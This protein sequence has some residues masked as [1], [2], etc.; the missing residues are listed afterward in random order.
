MMFHLLIS[1]PLS[2]AG[3]SI[4][5]NDPEFS[6]DVKTDLSHDELKEIIGRYDGLIIRS[7][8]RVDRDL[9]HEAHQ[10][11]IIGRAG[12]GV[13]NID[14]DAATKA[15]I[16]VVNAPD[17]NTISAAEHTLALLMALAR[18]IPN[19][20]LSLKRGEWDRKS[21]KGVELF[22]KT[23]GII[24]MGRIGAEVAKRAK[25]F[26]MD[27]LGYDP[28]LSE[29]KAKRLGIKRAE[30]ETIFSLAD[31]ITVH[32]PLTKD[33]RH[34]INAEALKKMKRGVRLINCA[35]G[36]IIDEKAL[37]EAIIAGHVGGCA[38]DVFENEP[39]KNHPLLELEQVIATPHLGAS[40]VE[41]QEKVAADVCREVLQ[42]FHG[43][44]ARHAL[45]LPAIPDDV[46]EVLD[47]YLGLGEK[48]GE[49]AGQLLDGPPEEVTISYSGEL[50]HLETAPL[51]RSILKGILSRYL[52]DHIN[53]INVQY[54]VKETGLTY[55][56]KREQQ[57][58][59]FVGLVK[60]ALSANQKQK[61][62]SGTLLNGYGPRI[63]HIDGFSV[64]LP[65][66]GHMLYIQ[67][68]DLPGLI[69][70]VGT[71]LGEHGINIGSMQVG[72]HSIGGRAIMVLTI[73]KQADE[74]ILTQI[75]NVSHIKEVR[76][77]DLSS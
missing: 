27:V 59:G 41:A 30:L 19:A 34:L 54:Y 39:P 20:Y 47:P 62:V 43:V 32:T 57:T 9:I 40:T 74:A 71:I 69:G 3:L 49:A 44:A 56:V 5:R 28:F 58:H 10:L 4:L 12:V 75:G 73:D 33:T 53:L 63:T 50:G 66:E 26:Q 24:G 14:L 37:Y 38:L 72:R 7:E 1:D 25:A 67:H 77:L 76:H 36:G 8:T 21:F 2:E 45:N 42:F 17:G 11:K 48:L 60:V 68:H 31:F 18:K 35:R 22:R 15:G 52:S 70:K 65:I 46:R 6:I 29:E 61:T 55:N 16:L 51:T 64:D 13:D 23:L